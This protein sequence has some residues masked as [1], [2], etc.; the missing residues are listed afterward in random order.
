MSRKY[1]ISTTHHRHKSSESK[2]FTDGGGCILTVSV[3]IVSGGISIVSCVQNATK[4]TS[5]Y[6]ASS[7]ITRGRYTDSICFRWPSS[8]YLCYLS[9][10]FMLQVALIGIPLPPFS[11][12]LLCTMLGSAR[13]LN[14]ACRPQVFTFSVCTSP[15]TPAPGQKLAIPQ[16]VKNSPSFMEPEGSLPCSQEPAIGPYIQKDESTPHLP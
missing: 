6:T 3:Q 10:V 14:G 1:V 9:V 8:E 2:F 4:T 11:C 5:D 7:Q 16:V 13:E 15:P 12:F